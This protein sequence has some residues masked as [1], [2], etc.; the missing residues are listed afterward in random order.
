MSSDP[1]VIHVLQFSDCHLFADPAE[2]LMG[3]NVWRSLT[4]VQALARRIDPAPDLILASGDLVHDE[5]QEAYGRLARSFSG[6]DAPVYC[7]PGNHDDPEMMKRLLTAGNVSVPGEV[8]LGGWQFVFLDSVIPGMVEGRLSDDELA[9][10][11]ACLAAGR[12]YHALLCVH[13]QPVP[14]GSPWM[15]DIGLSN[16]ADLW[17]VIADFPQ[18]RGVVWGHIHQEYDDVRR[19]IRLLGCPATCMQFLPN[20]DRCI[21]D[22]RPPGYRQLSLHADGTIDTAVRRLC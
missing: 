5:S 15:D 18:V 7:L 3:V 11:E 14:I 10:L 2:I 9:R 8:W 1:G 19:G 16:S 21:V 6:F 20:S 17:R 22:S 12:D 4:E 13:H